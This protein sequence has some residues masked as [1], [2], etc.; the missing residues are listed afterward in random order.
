MLNISRKYSIKIL[1][2]V[3]NV[4]Y[5]TL[6]IYLPTTFLFCIMI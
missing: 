6:I 2:Y 4:L 3:E 1:K 5:L